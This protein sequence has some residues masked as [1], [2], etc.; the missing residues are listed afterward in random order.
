M[1]PKT[2]KQNLPKKAKSKPKT[3]TA[4]EL[5]ATFLKTSEM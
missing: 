1:K 3:K 5:A 4:E 2:K